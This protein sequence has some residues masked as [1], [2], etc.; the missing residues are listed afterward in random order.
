MHE[1]PECG[2]DC[3]CDIDDTWDDD[4]EFCEHNCEFEGDDDGFDEE[5]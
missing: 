5:C 2:H 4:P 1:C 3:D